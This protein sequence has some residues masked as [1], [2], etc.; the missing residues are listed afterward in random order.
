MGR[1]LG[2]TVAASLLAACGPH[3][4]EHP[5]E[6]RTFAAKMD[7]TCGQELA[8]TTFVARGAKWGE[9]VRVEACAVHGLTGYVYVHADRS[10]FGKIGWNGMFGSSD[11]PTSQR[12]NGGK[13][14]PVADGGGG[15]GSSAGGSGGG[16]G[17]AARTAA[18]AEVAP[19]SMQEIVYNGDI[20]GN[21]MSTV[22]SL[23]QV[24]K[25]STIQVRVWTKFP[26]DLLG[27]RIR[28]THNIDKPNVSDKEWEKHLAKQRAEDEKR[29]R[30]EEKK[31]KKEK[32][33]ARLPEPDPDEPWR[34]PPPPRAELKPPAPSASSEWVPGYWH[35][36]AK[37]W[38]WIAGRWQVPPAE[39]YATV[40]A[41]FG[42]PPPR[43]EAAP[44]VAF[45]LVWIPG[46]WAWDG[47][48]YVWVGGG[49]GRPPRAGL[50]WRPATWRARGGGSVSFVPGGWSGR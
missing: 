16:S 17:A 40:T 37:D 39:L 31:Q 2:V 12:C 45:G 11:G 6:S 8:T 23:G 18:P 13:V 35:W 7:A 49:W 30:E 22:M 38:A 34:A 29:W 15:G 27:A 14:V 32:K 28:I 21:T 10:D 43:D 3:L 24:E 1:I 25:G 4:V 47:R 33:V 19:S 9:S 46:Y 26:V 44:A 48:T 36:A 41:P 20:C 42:P 50:S 5:V